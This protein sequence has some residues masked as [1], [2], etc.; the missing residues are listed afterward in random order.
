MSDI[1]SI[2]GDTL[3]ALERLMRMFQLERLLYL[4][5]AF[6]SFFLLLFCVWRLFTSGQVGP[7]ELAMIFGA[8]GLIATSAA[9]VSYFLNKSF[10]LIASI[11]QELVAIRSRDRNE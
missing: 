3:S 10:D 7:P 8:T 9:R 6:V 4:V 2:V 11:I 5:C 1:E